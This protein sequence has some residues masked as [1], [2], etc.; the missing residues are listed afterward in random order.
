M[1][2]NIIVALIAILPS[3]LTIIITN[4]KDKKGK[5]LSSF[6][7]DMVS[8]MLDLRNDMSTRDTE[9]KAILERDNRESLKRYLVFILSRARDNEDFTFNE[10]EKNIIKES[11]ALYREEHGNSYV[12]D[13]YEWCRNAGKL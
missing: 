5:V 1:S 12:K 8:S 10:Y 3:L 9:L 11:Y 2:E 6:K 4:V 13:L 7:K